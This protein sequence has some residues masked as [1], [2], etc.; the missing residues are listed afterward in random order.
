MSW[1]QFVDESLLGT[2]QVAKASIHGLNGERYASSS[3][4]VVLPSEAQVL[5]AA[6]TKDPSPTYYKGVC[7]NR[8]KYFV[9]RVDPGHSL[10]CRKGNEGA[11]AVLTSQCLLIGA[12][13]EG[14]TPGCCSA[15]TEKLADY[16]RVNG[17]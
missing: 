2:S 9:I 17:F 10:Y 5:I 12:Y 15:V 6:I 14:M 7:L 4:F 8:T 1:Q 13:S 11:V 3:G 16:F